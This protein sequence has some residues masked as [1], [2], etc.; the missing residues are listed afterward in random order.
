MKINYLSFILFLLI[1]SCSNNNPKTRSTSPRATKKKI[2]FDA[3]KAEM[4]GNADWVVGPT[5]NMGYNNTGR[6][7]EGKSNEANPQRFPTQA[8]EITKDTKE[9]FWTGALSAWA[10]D[11][12]KEGFY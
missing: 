6:M 1:C 3:T 8:Q 4:C 10:I 9:N 7:M 12:V 2:F 5:T 11:C